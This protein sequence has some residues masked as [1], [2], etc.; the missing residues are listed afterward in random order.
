MKI[1]SK[2]PNEQGQVLVWV[3]ILLPLLIALTGLVFDG[4][5]LWAQYR[6]A[7][8]SADGAAVA[9]A[10]DIDQVLYRD[11][12]QVRLTEQALYTAVY[13]ARE[14]DP[15]LRISTIYVLNNVI[16]VQGYVHVEPIFLGLFGVDGLTLNVRGRERPAWG[17]SQEGE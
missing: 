10:S 15:D 8:W 12:G 4:G 3:V 13:Y 1:K 7:R 2:L 5:L 6:R 9:A 14:N 11:Q 17:I 16:Y